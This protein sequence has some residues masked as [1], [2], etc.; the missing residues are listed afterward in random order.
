[1]STSEVIL[2]QINSLVGDLVEMGLAQ[3]QNYVFQRKLSSTSVEVTFPRAEHLSAVF[4]NQPYS[5]VY[6]IL[7]AERA[8]VVKL[9]DG[10]LIQMQ[11]LFE[12]GALERHRLAFFPS[13]H[14]EEFQNN[15][16]VYLEDA[17]YADIISRS[18]VP[19]P[20]HFDYDCR[21][22]IWK[23]LKHPKSH[24][25]LGQY[26]NCRIPVSAPLAPACFMDFVLRN[27][28]NTAFIQYSDKL[29][30]SP[31]WFDDSILAAEQGVIYIK[32][33]TS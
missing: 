32:I 17:A 20:L 11:Y 7:A 28:Y 25:S 31:W 5:E 30:K 10:A 21:D 15:P 6:D 33:P 4:N 19:F 24:L 23:E 9:P 12:G 27:F 13:P 26:E 8:L 14:L 3:D 22:S 2:K 1:M 16:E 29:L 18:I